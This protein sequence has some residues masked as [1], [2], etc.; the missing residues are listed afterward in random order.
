M[1][2]K[3]R[4]ALFGSLRR[5][6]IV[7]VA[8]VHA[9]MMSLFIW[10]MTE[11]QEDMLLDQQT[12]QATALAQSVATS[13]ATWLAARD[14][15]GLQE[16]IDA[17]Q[18]YPELLYAMAIDRN[19]VILAHTDRNLRGRSLKDLPSEA[20]L[21]VLQH[22][23]A[24]VDVASPALVGN[25]Q[26]GWVRVGLG[27]ESI[28][29]DLA[30]IS[31]NGLLYALVAIL[32][33]GLLAFVMGTRL[34]RRLYAIQSVADAVESGDTNQRAATE[35]HDEA[36][37]LARQ[38]NLMLD[39]L[40]LRERELVASHD[41]LSENEAKYRTL[42]ETM[43]QGVIF[44]DQEG[45]ITSA[46][47]AAGSILGLSQEQLIGRNVDDPGWD[48]VHED[49]S[50][51]PAHSQPAMIALH[52]GRPVYDVIMGVF[53]SGDNDYRWL[54]V[55][56]IPRFHAGASAAYQVFVTFTDISERKRAEA[57]V[58]QLN[59]QLEQRVQERT[60][61]LEAAVR[62]LESFA[63]SVSHDLRGPLR[64]ID[65][66]SQALSEDYGDKLDAPGRDYLRRVRAAAQRM[67]QII[68][69]LLRLSR[70]SRAPLATATVDL[71][72]LAHDILAHLRESQPGRQVTVQV[73]D[74]LQAEGD[75]GLLRVVLEN[76]LGNAW[77]YT[78][79]R[80]AAR[81]EFSRTRQDS[82][83]VFC[84]RDNGVGFDMQYAD[85]L[86]GAFQ[87]LHHPSEFE[88][89]GI[90]LATVQRIVHRHGGRTWAESVPGQ[91]AVV[92]FTLSASAR[93]SI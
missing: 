61:Q 27:Q 83:D 72:A 9:V 44:M 56:A 3:L 24:L 45:H 91:G 62:E 28:S 14:V 32:I 23:A 41:A 80:E 19:G 70:V 21:A 1:L 25:E 6:L 43:A 58:F 51:F 15:T 86:F 66:F 53:H 37:R 57:K 50:N 38:F 78:G 81:I 12:R 77:K 46:N 22:S 89:T 36:A 35:G 92:Y 68:D 2:H 55:N 31:R 88:G 48:I 13:A 8:T 34:T 85:K 76:L 11:R 7:G 52:S 93:V 47:P 90:G 79:K 42:F 10:D 26:Y 4:L 71:S 59:T 17:Q 39:T 18:R 60:A 29:D 49:G 20:K 73:Q 84:V 82:E 87:R 5:Q 16:I 74:G 67:G 40:A 63:Y 75:P 69:D 30:K 33:G 65:G 64:G 54:L